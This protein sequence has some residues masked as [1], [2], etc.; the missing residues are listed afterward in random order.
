VLATERSGL[1]YTN[2]IGYLL[3]RDFKYLYFFTPKNTV[4][5]KNI[6]I[7]PK[8]SILIDNRDKS[9]NKKSLITAVTIIGKASIIRNFDRNIINEFLFYYPEL[10]EFTKPGLNSLVK[11]DIDKYIL[12]SK[13]QH[14]IEV[15]P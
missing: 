13:L 9:S 7:N 4:K 1:P 14:V 8:V 12:V 3:S 6:E 15:K 2:L 11:V 10:M 5:Y